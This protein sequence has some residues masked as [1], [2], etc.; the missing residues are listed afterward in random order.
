MYY[1]NKL[2]TIRDIQNNIKHIDYIEF[3]S[4]VMGILWNKTRINGYENI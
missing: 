1:T 2:V 3:N 4:N